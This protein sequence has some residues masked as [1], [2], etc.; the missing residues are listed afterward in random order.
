MSVPRFPPRLYTLVPIGSKLL[1]AVNYL[2]ILNGGFFVLGY[3]FVTNVYQVY[4]HFKSLRQ[5][6]KYGYNPLRTGT[7]PWVA[8]SPFIVFAGDTALGQPWYY[9]DFGLAPL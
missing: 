8:Q 6:L 3:N 2:R 4:G 7:P 9:V 5:A 1:T